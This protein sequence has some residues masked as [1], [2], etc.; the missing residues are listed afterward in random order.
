MH[1]NEKSNISDVHSEVFLQLF[2][3]H[4]EKSVDE[5]VVAGVAHGQPVGAEPDHVDI[6]VPAI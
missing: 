4:V 5:G 6:V 2:G 1:F 3:T